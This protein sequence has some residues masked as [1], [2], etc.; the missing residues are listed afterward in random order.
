MQRID[1]V[2][3]AVEVMQAALDE[4]EAPACVLLSDEDRPFWDAVIAARP[5]VE[6]NDADLITAGT[7]AKT[8]RRLE[9]ATDAKEIDTLARLTLAI[10]RSLGLDVRGKDGRASDVAKRR[11]QAQAIQQQVPKRNYL[12]LN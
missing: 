8:M 3:A 1:S 2:T 10:R 5:N 12:G 4:I 11:K 7:L 6:W 9:T